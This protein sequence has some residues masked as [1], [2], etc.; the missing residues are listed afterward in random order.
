VLRNHSLRVEITLVRIEITVVSVVITFVR[1]KITLCVMKSYAAC[2]NH[3]LRVEITLL[4][5]VHT[6]TVMNTRTN[7]I[8]ERKM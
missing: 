8:S 4:C 6:H 1:V 5:D 2:G 3:T 7:V